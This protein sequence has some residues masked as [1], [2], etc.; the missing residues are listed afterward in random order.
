M[1]KL[2]S[3]LEHNPKMTQLFI[4]DCENESV[5]ETVWQCLENQQLQHL[6]LVNC[7]LSGGLVLSL[8]HAVKHC[9]SLKRLHLQR[10][11]LCGIHQQSG[12]GV[13][14]P[15]AVKHLLESTICDSHLEELEIVGEDLTCVGTK[16]D[17]VRSL[18]RVIVNCRDLR[19][20]SLREC[21]LMHRGEQILQSALH[22][23]CGSYPILSVTY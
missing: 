19:K 12:H 14:Q 10:V 2:S 20:V 3:L 22:E 8:A 11:A 16:W 21:N 1:F 9:H 4:S 17:I 13:Y 6:K 7:D 23:R 15:Y 18:A 5:L